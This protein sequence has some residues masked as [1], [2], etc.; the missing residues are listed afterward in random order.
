MIEGGDF[1]FPMYLK[2]LK[3][4]ENQ[5]ITVEKLI[6]FL[7]KEKYFSVKLILYKSPLDDDKTAYNYIALEIKD[8]ASHI[9]A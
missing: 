2:N 7:P 8:D 5:D 9:I 1:T 4:I 6:N 3:R